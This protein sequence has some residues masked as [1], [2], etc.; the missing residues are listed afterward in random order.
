VRVPPPA[1]EAAAVVYAEQTINTGWR[2]G[3]SPHGDKP[4]TGAVP[5]SWRAVSLPHTVTPLGYAAWDYQAWERSWGYARTVYLADASRGRRT[6]ID[7]DG[8]LTTTTVAFNG[9]TLGTNVGGYLPFSF[10]V[11]GHCRHGANELRVALDGRAAGEIPPGEVGA[12]APERS[13][14]FLQPGGLYRSAHLRTTPPVYLYDVFVNPQL[15]AAGDGV[16]VEVT[17]DAE[18]LAGIMDVTVALIDASG[19]TVRSGATTVSVE[20]GRTVAR[21]TVTGPALELWSPETPTCYRA[22]TTL[23]SGSETVHVTEVRTG[24]RYSVFAVDGYRLN[25]VARTLMGLSSH[26]L[27]PWSGHAAPARAQADDV[28]VLRNTLNLDFVRAVHYPHDPAFLDACDTLGLLVWEET[29]GWGNLGPSGDDNDRFDGLWAANNTA[30]V[31]RDR[32]RPSVIIW[33]THPNEA[34][35]DPTLDTPRMR[36]AHD[37]DRDRPT[38]GACERAVYRP[39]DYVEDVVAINDYESGFADRSGGYTARKPSELPATAYLERPSGSKPWLVTETV[40]ALVPPFTHYQGARQYGAMAQGIYH[41]QVHDQAMAPGSGFAGVSAWTAFDYQSNWDPDPDHPG[42]RSPGVVDTFRNP[43]RG[44]GFYLSQGDPDG[45]GGA[46]VV[47]GFAWW[48]EVS[49]PAQH[50]LDAHDTNSVAC[51]ADA[52]LNVAGAGRG[53]IWSNCD[54]VQVFL[55]GEMTATLRPDRSSYPNLAHPPMWMP[56]SG[57]ADRPVLTLVGIVGDQEVVNTS[58]APDADGATLTV[59][60][61]SASIAHDG[62][63]ATRV[64]VL[65]T[66]TFGN[67]LPYATGVCTVSVSGAGELIGDTAKGIDFG[68]TGGSG[69]VWVRAAVGKAPGSGTT[70]RFSHPTYGSAQT[71]VA[72]A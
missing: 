23:S 33:G 3:P 53:V 45:P 46:V 61:D 7:F 64:S 51:L 48:F 42:L 25:G 1:D 36:I 47:P 60:A 21:L 29:P 27:R 20:Q 54:E 8:A 30:M 34:P 68:D 19:A 4:V 10:E 24:F 66:D 18:S 16:N 2:F 26:Q 62:S 37:L 6:F 13:I 11:T 5:S 70:V 15:A 41:A 22:R 38:A 59:A 28:A 65:A 14:D 40:G 56:L 31:L 32:S 57:I 69:A 12:V 35:L 67:H 63:D 49:G 71:R 44:A 43:K 17:V 9:V 72:F 50:G 55:N 39:A 52:K 58:Y